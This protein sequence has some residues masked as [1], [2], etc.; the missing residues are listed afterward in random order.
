MKKLFY[1][2]SWII[3]NGLN[4]IMIRILRECDSPY[5]HSCF[6]VTNEKTNNRQIFCKECRNEHSNHVLMVQFEHGM[7][8]KNIILD[9]KMFNT[10][11]GMADY[12]GV[13]FVTIYH[14]I[15]K[16]LSM[17]FQ[18]F[19]RNHICKSEKCY[20]INISDSPYARGD[21][22]LKKIRDQRYCAC[23]NE[24]GKH[25]MMTNAPKAIVADIL[26]VDKLIIKDFIY[27]KSNK[28][29]PVYTNV[30]L[31]PIYFKVVLFPSPI[32]FKISNI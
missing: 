31:F 28:L 25:Y 27:K 22:I 24:L 30:A 11:S 20:L 17:T 1:D 32:Y 29:F 26:G 15:K 18:E 8:I 13:S 23:I 9:A 6:F 4:N 10:A 14:W 3:L 12:I 2:I 7:D 21:Y 5:C 19:R 16:Y